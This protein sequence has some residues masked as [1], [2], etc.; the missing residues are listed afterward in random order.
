MK[1]ETP[2]PGRRSETACEAAPP[3]RRT[4]PVTEVR[5]TAVQMG[6]RRV[7]LLDA[8]GSVLCRKYISL[9]RLRPAAP[10][11]LGEAMWQLWAYW[12]R[13]KAKKHRDLAVRL[14]DPWEAKAEGWEC[15]LRLRKR[16]TAMGGGHNRWERYSTATWNDALKR[17]WQQAKNQWKKGSM[18]RWERWSRTASRNLARRRDEHEGR[19]Q[20]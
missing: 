19:R 15:S 3:K 11:L 14:R 9:G 5:L 18:T 2:P 12:Q 16:P 17:L 13:D 20:R 7:V 8:R 10:E 1:G 6:R 4:M